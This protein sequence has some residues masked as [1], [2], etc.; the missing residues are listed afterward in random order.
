M[1]TDYE[2]SLEA[3]KKNIEKV[4]S[5]INISQKDLNKYGEYK[6]KV[7][8]PSFDNLSENLILVT[9]I[10][11]T[12]T[13]EGKSTVT[14]GL[15]DGM[16][17]I[18]KK[19]SVALR[20]PSLGPVLGRKGG[21]TGGGYAQV[22]PM[23]EINLHFTGDFH[24]I[25]S[26]HNAIMALINNHIFQGNKLNFDKIDFNYVMDMNERALRSVE[27]YSNGKLS[28]PKSSSFDI[29][30]ASEIMAILCLS[31]NIFDLKKRVSNII[32]GYTRESKP[33]YLREL[34]IE[35]VIVALLKDAIRPN[36][37]QTLEN[38]PAFIHGGP[39]ANIAHG[40]NSV[41]A[42]KTALKYSDYVITEAGFGADLGAE[43][44]FNIKC[45]SAKLKPKAVVIV[46]T[47][48]A[49]K[50]HGGVLEKDLA[51]ENL[52][53]LKIGIKNLEKHVENIRKFNLPIVIALNEFTTD[54][55]REKEFLLKWA[56]SHDVEI[57]LTQVWSKG[58]EGAIDLS[59]KLVNLIEKN[60][61]EF[62]LLY[63]DEDLIEDKINIIAKQVYGATSVKFTDSAREK[64]K[65]INDL[66]YSN[67]PV[68]MAKTPNSLSDNPKLLGRPENFQITISDL[69]IN[70][71]AGFIVAYLNKVLTMPG[72]PKIPNA[73]SIDI[74]ENENII[75][76]F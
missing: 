39:F 3:N 56:K 67:L 29:T 5:K 61:K 44:F 30:V 57:S 9:S 22:V 46:A 36:L 14:V 43:K 49:I 11:P 64:L 71:G 53:A 58:G 20:E 15:C 18:G 69:K 40:C 41:I 42:T 17:L 66:G 65:L 12:S 7:N 27:I 74:D 8:I 62:N 70:S 21:A 26:A 48:K 2:I 28:S 4:A 51:Q 55:D 33:I 45:R 16:N 54:T 19:T 13:G 76:L 31:E 25:T 72:L 63:K 52:E 47:I 37:V 59:K 6:A 34:K 10:N 24:A 73:I 68:C 60:N 32:L 23:D 1:K 35:G 38:N 75:N 50:L